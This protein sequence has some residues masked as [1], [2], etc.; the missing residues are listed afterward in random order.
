MTRNEANEKLNKA[1]ALIFEVE[2]QFKEGE[3]PR[4]HGYRARI[5]VGALQNE[6]RNHLTNTPVV[7]G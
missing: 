6:L 5:E 3:Y 4:L 7:V 2:S 1:C